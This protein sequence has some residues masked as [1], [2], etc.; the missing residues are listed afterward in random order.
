MSITHYAAKKLIDYDSEKSYAFRLRKKRAQRIKILIN[1]AYRLHHRVNILDVGGTKVYWKLLSKKFLLDRNVHITVLNLPTAEPL[2]ENDELFTFIN[3]DGC[4]LSPFANKSFH[5]AHSNS[6]IEHVGSMKNM[7]RFANAIQGV[8][9]AY[10]VQ[11][12]NYWFPLEPHFMTPFF[13]W[14][15]KSVRAQ[16]IMQFKLGWYPKAKSLAEAN[17]MVESCNLLAK[18]ELKKLFP[19]AIIYTEKIG[20]LSKSF[21][22][23]SQK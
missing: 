8:A 21:I 12:P 6:V 13:H 9:H 5:I 3:G 4:D 19:E 18:K 17:G 1:N 20:L 16:L 15:P 11:T 2:P 23:I 10:Y 22:L 14:F 7:K